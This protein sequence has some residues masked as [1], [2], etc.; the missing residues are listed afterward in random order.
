MLG[1]ETQNV[2]K[3]QQFIMS[4]KAQGRAHTRDELGTKPRGHVPGV[5]GSD[6]PISMVILLT[7]ED[8]LTGGMDPEPKPGEGKSGN[9][10]D[11]KIVRGLEDKIEKNCL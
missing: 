2:Y 3:R 6:M 7:D 9:S 11:G 5:V 4:H 8:T 10:E 1:N